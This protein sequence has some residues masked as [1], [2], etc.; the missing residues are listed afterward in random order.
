MGIFRKNQEESAFNIDHKGANSV[1]FRKWG[2]AKSLGNGIC[3]RRV[4]IAPET[5]LPLRIAQIKNYYLTKLFPNS[6]TKLHLPGDRV[7]IGQKVYNPN[8]FK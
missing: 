1:I 8:C 7:P 2:T 5:F 3:R 6:K 4:S